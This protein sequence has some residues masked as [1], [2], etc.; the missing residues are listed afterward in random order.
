MYVKWP[1][2]SMG[3]IRLNT[4][5]AL[6]SNKSQAGF[7]GVFRNHKGDWVMGYTGHHQLS[8]VIDI[9]LMALLR[10]LQIAIMHHLTPLEIQMDAQEEITMFKTHA[11]Q[12]SPLIIDCRFL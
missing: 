4:D 5:G 7:G 6:N 1:P 2:P 11:I 8:N 3:I 10:G 9:E 12:Y